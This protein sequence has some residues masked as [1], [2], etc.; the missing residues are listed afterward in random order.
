MF[1]VAGER[2]RGN[3]FE[4]SARV[5]AG[6]AIT[7]AAGMFRGEFIFS[8]DHAQNLDGRSYIAQNQLGS[9]AQIN[10]RLMQEYFQAENGCRHDRDVIQEI[11]LLARELSLWGAEAPPGR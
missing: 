4:P 9:H 11:R 7:H 8:P 10:T 5:K 3:C 1:P 2:S 6:Q